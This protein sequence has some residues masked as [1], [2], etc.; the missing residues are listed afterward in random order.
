MP[1]EWIANLRLRLRALWKRRKLDEDLDEE[2]RFH[3]A[4]REFELREGGMDA[5]EAARSAR[6]RFGN[7]T[8][9]KEAA[10][11]LWTFPTLESVWKDLCYGARVLRQNPLF[12]AVAV[13]S[14]ALGI[15]ANTSVF[16]LI[17]AVML[18]KLPVP[19]PEELVIFNWSARTTKDV[20]Q[21]NSF[22]GRDPETGRQTWNVFPYSAFPRFR[23]QS[24]QLSSVFAFTSLRSAAVRVGDVTEMFPGLLVSGDFY[25]GM[26]AKPLVGR[27]LDDTDDTFGAPAVAVISNQLWRD[28]FGAN[29]RVIGSLTT[30]NGIPVTIVGVTQPEFYGPSPGGPVPVPDI[31][32]PLALTPEVMP[33]MGDRS[34]FLDDH[35]WWLNVMGRLRAGATIESAQSELDALF[36][37]FLLDAQIESE[38][39]EVVAL[40]GA[41]G[42][43]AI[44]M[45]LSAPL[46][47]LLVA[48]GLV[49]LIACTNLATLMLS[50]ASAR[51]G[52][53]TVR[54]AMGAGR[55]RLI[56]QLLTES[57]LLSLTG[58]VLGAAFSYWGCRVLL[59]WIL[60]G[61]LPMSLAPDLTVLGFIV[62]LSVAASI[63]FG[64][65]PAFFS[66]RVDLVPALNARTAIASGR[67]SHGGRFG[68]GFI[69]VQVALSLTLI[70][71]AGLFLRTLR[72][73]RNVD[74]GFQSD[75]LLVF[76]V[77]PTLTGYE[78]DRLFVFYRDLLA[79]LSATSGVV[80]ATASENR[81]VT[82]SMSGGPVFVP[83]ATWLE[84]G[85]V[86]VHV[87]RI[88]PHYFETMRIPLLLG[89]GPDE[90]D[91]ASAPRVVFINEAVA[92]EAF[93]DSSPL[94][95]TIHLW[96]A[97]QPP[98]EIAGVVANAHYTGM[99]EEPPPTV[100]APY[101][102]DTRGIARLHFTI[103]TAGPPEAFA[104]TARAV[105]TG[106]DP[107]LPVTNIATER[108]IIDDHLRSERMFASLSTAFGV[109][110]LLLASIGI[111]GVIAYATDRRTGEVG[112]RMALGAQFGSI[113]WLMLRRVTLLVVLG[114]AAGAVAAY[115]LTQYIA[116]TLYGI[117]SSDPATFTAAAML[118]VL[119]ALIAGFF[120]ARRAARV[121]PMEALRCE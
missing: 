18:E 61:S 17:N 56:R 108:Q 106:L 9:T 84:N 100:Y 4:M 119:V 85:A 117:E 102:Q 59:R 1:S 66:S 5:G 38:E 39:M 51:I 3:V 64:L 41:H 7:S 111:Y 116:G 16:T 53:I 72:N 21:S 49:L 6:R 73:L 10:R 90:R 52:E 89:R 34:L 110:A 44:R 69:V 79:R 22:S 98:A 30:V 42:I 121:P 74:L 76:T 24:K 120:P 46:W 118:L 77:D 101:E 37:Q 75:S 105:V 91:T 14:L 28:R 55:W 71:G 88:G 113:V 29:P 99:R 82:G 40:P 68:Q 80:S 103:R 23:A 109:L 25:A 35:R 27:L 81:L 63:L 114:V 60:P 32:L 54:L 26:G 62:G 87:N 67:G 20:S 12:T 2:L 36:T 45:M 33:A 96:G 15:G 11:E 58:G 13:L 95:R 92:N 47:T 86:Q 31:T 78:G 107:D 8:G 43:G 50:R 93:P 94:G 112:L 65:A 115:W 83:G 70:I 97:D 57:L 19:A 104:G 48:T